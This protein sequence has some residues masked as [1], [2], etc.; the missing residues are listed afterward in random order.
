[1]P[2]VQNECLYPEPT[3]GERQL[4]YLFTP[5]HH[6]CDR[7]ASQWLPELTLEQEFCIFNLGVTHLIE[8]DRGYLYSIMPG[9]TPDDSP[10]TIGTEEQQI[11]EFPFARDGEPWHGYPQY[12]LRESDSRNRRRQNRRPQNRIFDR[13][14]EVGLISPRQRRRLKKGAA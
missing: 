14:V 7:Q 13:M 5:K 12:P 2:I 10:R 11:A 3:T 6:G 4:R 8:D 9:D 1:M